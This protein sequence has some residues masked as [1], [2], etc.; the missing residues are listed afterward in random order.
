MSN[1][2][3][4]AY[5]RDKFNPSTHVINISQNFCRFPSECTIRKEFRQSH[6]EVKRILSTQISINLDRLRV[7]SRRSFMLIQQIG[8]L[9][10][11]I[12]FKGAS[13]ALCIEMTCLHRWKWKLDFFQN[14][15]IH[16]E[17][18][19]LIR[20][21]SDIEN[22]RIYIYIVVKWPLC[23]FLSWELLMA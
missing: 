19:W 15:Q 3:N 5:L 17:Y 10:K 20:P 22:L 16:P 9:C 13:I 4:S 18:M 7:L 14:F 8:L 12:I 6:E 21:L 23:G 11:K 2:L 1:I